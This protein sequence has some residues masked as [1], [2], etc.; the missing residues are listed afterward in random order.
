MP[1]DG[2]LGDAAV[3]AVAMRE[4]RWRGRL[5]LL[6]LFGMRGPVFLSRDLSR[7]VALDGKTRAGWREAGIAAVSTRHAARHTAGAVRGAHAPKMGRR[8]TR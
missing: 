3:D 5:D 4:G 8:Y 2:A 6:N 7:R 1:A